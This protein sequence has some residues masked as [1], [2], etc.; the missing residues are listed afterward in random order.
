MSA[1]HSAVRR[2]ELEGRTLS[3]RQGSTAKLSTSPVH[4]EPHAPFLMALPTWP[5]YRFVLLV[6]GASRRSAAPG[7]QEIWVAAFFSS[8]RLHQKP[9]PAHPAPNTP[10]LLGYTIS[11]YPEAS[12]RCSS[13]AGAPTISRSGLTPRSSG[14]P[15]A[16]RLPWRVYHPVRVA[17]CQAPLSSNVRPLKSAPA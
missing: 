13:T 3:L 12:A 1:R 16:G 6:N 17:G 5:T 15:T 9:A 11:G 10:V 4:L 14:A 2:G 8:A 7:S